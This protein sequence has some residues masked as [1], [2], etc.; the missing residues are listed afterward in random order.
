MFDD[1]SDGLTRPI[2]ARLWD[3]ATQT[4][5][6]AIEFTPED[7]GELVGGSRFKALPVPIKLEVDFQGTITAEGYGATE[8]LRNRLNNPANIIWPTL[9]GGGSVAFVGSSRYGLTVGLF[10]DGVDEG[11][12]ASYA[13][14]TFEFQTT[15]PLLPG[16]TK[17]SARPGDR[18]VLLTW[19]PVTAPLPA[20]R[21]Q[22]LRA[23]DSGGPFTQIAAVEATNHMDTGLVNG[24]QV[25]DIVRAVATNGK[26][27]PDS[28]VK[29]TVP[30]A[31]PDPP[32][33]PTSQQLPAAI[34]RW[35]VRSD[36]TS[37][38]SNGWASSTTARTAWNLPLT[39]RIYN[40]ETREG[41]AEVAFAPAE[42][43]S[44]EG[45]RF[46]A[47][48]SPLRLE[49][50]FKG[51]IQADGYGAEERLLNSSG[52]TN[53]VIW[54]LHDGNGSIRFVGSSRYGL[55]AE[56][57]PEI[58]DGGPAA[59]F[60][61]VTFE[62]EGL[63]PERPRT[64]TRNVVVPYED[65]AVTL[66]WSAV[67]KPLPATKYRVFRATDAA[68]PFTLVVETAETTY[69]DTGLQNGVEVFYLIRSMAEGGQV[70]ADSNRVQSPRIPASQAWRTSCPP[71]WPPPGRTA[72][73]WE[74]I[75][76]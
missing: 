38:S 50:G 1:G 29:C 21:Y 24:V 47:L 44:I 60:A 73:R 45:M 39:A 36:R 42:D 16:K 8:R 65:A 72:V 28:D 34:R 68:G 2:T 69:R 5:W 63:P 32:R 22:V 75:S 25:C 27:G 15:P 48:E 70:S 74:W 71:G 43:E 56:A 30:Y 3:R 11:P 33:S 76:T 46:K 13:A 49:A 64:P 57:F 54:I 58:L 10:P 53:R 18:Q 6:A 4:E 40:R 37:T 41:V 14:G 17:V 20:A 19:T 59:R 55:T 31:L 67:A 52:D 23:A 62:Y 35:A 51:V 7:S 12:A 26:V 9:I 61:A 66:F